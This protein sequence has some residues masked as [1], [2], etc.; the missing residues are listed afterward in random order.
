MSFF[1]N[2]FGNKTIEMESVNEESHKESEQ[3]ESVVQEEIQNQEENE[4]DEE[5][6][7]ETT[8]ENK[9]IVNNNEIINN[10]NNKEY[11]YVCYGEINYYDIKNADHWINIRC[12][13]LHCIHEEWWRVKTIRVYLKTNEDIKG[14]N[15]EEI[16]IYCN[17]I[18]YSNRCIFK[19]EFYI[20]SE[21]VEDATD[22]EIT[23]ERENG[24]ITKDIYSTDIYIIPNSGIVLYANK[25]FNTNNNAIWYIDE[26]SE[27][28]KSYK[29]KTWKEC[30]NEYNQNNSKI[31]VYNNF[32]IHELSDCTSSVTTDWKCEKSIQINTNGKGTGIVY[33]KSTLDSLENDSSIKRY[34]VCEFFYDNTRKFSTEHLNSEFYDI[35]PM[36]N[37]DYIT[38]ENEPETLFTNANTYL[39]CYEVPYHLDISDNDIKSHYYY[40]LWKMGDKEYS[41]DA[42]SNSVTFLFNCEYYRE[43]NSEGVVQ[44]HEIVMYG[45]QKMPIEQD[46]KSFDEG[47]NTVYTNLPF[48][49]AWN[50]KDDVISI[51]DDTIIPIF[52][53]FERYDSND[54]SKIYC[55]E[56]DA[57]VH[58]VFNTMMEFCSTPNYNPTNN[59]MYD[60]HNERTINHYFF[61]L[62]IFG[63]KED[64]CQT[65]TSQESW[66]V[67]NSGIYIHKGVTF[68]SP[69]PVYINLQGGP[70]KIE[71]TIRAPVLV[72][73]S[74]YEKY[75][76]TEP[77]PPQDKYW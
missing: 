29:Y 56:P 66:C 48:N 28:G 55:Y 69:I 47:R 37:N 1:F 51:L 49:M 36:S 67:F 31:T 11:D 72:I 3:E 40:N 64:T 6:V 4:N 14:L 74:D 23:I 2:L 68:E 19:V 22:S 13:Y 63:K 61:K 15:F 57:K 10:E 75:T 39:L 8:E 12:D 58:Y 73:H 7:E 34:N 59:E 62:K 54:P 16:T 46:T 50:Y 9:E 43:Y 53:R 5:S 70:I 44:W 30:S 20:Y 24:E 45:K 33:S 35:D 65:I 18:F 17:E 26:Y 32:N 76:I 25:I 71:G 27:N 60:I 41:L 38:I 42:Y 21:N 52:N 77:N